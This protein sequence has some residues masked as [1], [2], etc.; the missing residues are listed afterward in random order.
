MCHYAQY[1]ILT[2]RFYLLLSGRIGVHRD[3]GFMQSLRKPILFNIPAEIGDV[4]LYFASDMHRG[5]AEYNEQKWRGFEKLLEEPNA[6]VIFVGD[7]MENATRSSK[8]DV[9]TQTMRPHEQKQWWTNNMRPYKDKVIAIVDGNHEARSAKDADNFP[10]YDIALALGIEDRYRSEAAFVDIGV[11]QR[12]QCDERQHHYIGYCVHKAQN[13]VNYGTADAIDG[14]D[15]F[16]SGHTHK[17]MDKP[18]GKLVYNANKKSVLERSV[19]NIVSGSFLNYGGYAAR[20]GMRPASQ[21][22]HKLILNAT[23]KRIETIG[24]YI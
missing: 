3:G 22:L 2:K 1:N 8:S 13:L 12:R 15:F 23:E 16:V 6:Y 20:G 14:I 4:I 19:E 9:Y 5:S 21:K 11:G 7:Q 24:F 17:P 10:L 18:L